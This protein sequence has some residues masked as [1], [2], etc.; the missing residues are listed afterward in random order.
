[1][2]PKTIH[3]C[4]FGRNPLPPLAIEC[5]ESWRKFLPDYEIKEWNEDN[6]DV[7]MIPYTS[8]AY[9]EKKY[10]FVSDFARF[11]ILYHYGGLYFDTDVKVIKPMNDIIENGAFMGFERDPKKKRRGLVNPGL[12][13]GFE[14]EHIFLK[15]MLDYYERLHFIDNDGSLLTNK[16]IVHYTTDMLQCLGLNN[17]KLQ[18]ICDITVYPAEYFA[19]I[20]FVTKRLHITNNTRSI[21]CYMGSWANKKESFIEKIRMMLPEWLLIMINKCKRKED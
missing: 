3:Y 9:K 11:W 4:W 2:I 10:A 8:E 20:H 7:N 6:F 13:L 14:K 17:K 16:T 1:M 5:I 15:Q 18:Q 19:P 12:G 21:H